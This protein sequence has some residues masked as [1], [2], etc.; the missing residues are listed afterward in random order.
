MHK[1]TLFM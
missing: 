1:H